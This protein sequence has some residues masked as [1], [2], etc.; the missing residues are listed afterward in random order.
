M[1]R[2]RG[3]AGA[4]TSAWQQQAKRG[5]RSAGKQ[6]ELPGNSAPKAPAPAVP[7]VEAMPEGWLDD[8]E[9][10]MTSVDIVLRMQLPTGLDAAAMAGYS[11]VFGFLTSQHL[12]MLAAVEKPDLFEMVLRGAW[13]K[14]YYCIDEA[15]AKP[16]LPHVREN[17]G[18]TGPGTIEAR[19]NVCA[20]MAKALQ[21]QLEASADGCLD[22]G[23]G[24]RAT[25]LIGDHHIRAVTMSGAIGGRLP[26]AR[27]M[28]F[29]A[30]AKFPFEVLRVSQP[31]KHFSSA[32]SAPAACY[33][34]VIRYQGSIDLL[35]KSFLLHP[36]RPDGVMQLHWRNPV[37]TAQ[38]GQVIAWAR[39]L[40]QFS[41]YIPAS[42]KP[43]ARQQA[44][45]GG[46][47]GGAGAGGAGAPGAGDGPPNP[48]GGGGGEQGTAQQQPQQEHEGAADA[49]AAAGAGAGGEAGAAAAGQGQD[50]PAEEGAPGARDAAATGANGGAA[51]GEG[52]GVGGDV[53][54]GQA[55]A[56]QPAAP[57]PSPPSAGGAAKAPGSSRGTGGKAQ[58][59][60][61]AS[62]AA[63][64]RRQAAA[65]AAAEA[66]AAEAGGA[67]EQAGSSGGQP[68]DAGQVQEP[69][70]KKQAVDPSADAV[71][72]GHDGDVA[73]AHPAPA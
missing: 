64:A 43:A 34:A 49:D 23:H 32:D 12:K 4:G 6:P 55:P 63:A 51:A 62:V 13:G 33:T 61:E 39:E 53:G 42:T 11:S 30:A 29:F 9:A 56:A 38:A 68:P 5:R 72:I 15:A 2:Q 70:A 45:G 14:Q 21:Q 52:S 69:A 65:A 73:A 47:T 28:E 27:M 35:P 46:G 57:A 18:N 25:A 36:S 26:A 48:A 3:A 16:V 71:P 8:V 40:K 31:A 54:G 50:Q 60:A 67:P 59:K 17:A 41:R 58:Q 19:Y 66:A 22:L 1:Q 10:A 37:P 44:G 20:G 7:D 24:L